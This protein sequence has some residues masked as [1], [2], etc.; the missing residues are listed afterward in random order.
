MENER[1][2]FNAVVLKIRIVD[3]DVETTEKHFFSTILTGISKL[4]SCVQI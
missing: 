3:N 2:S 4:N 1:L